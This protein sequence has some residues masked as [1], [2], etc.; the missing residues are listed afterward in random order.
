MRHQ[1]TGG[2]LGI[3]CEWSQTGGE[4]TQDLRL[5]QRHRGKVGRRWSQGPKEEEEGE[6]IG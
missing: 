6:S 1:E 2:G 4:S 5:R 3:K